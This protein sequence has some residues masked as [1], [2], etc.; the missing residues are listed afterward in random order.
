MP[1]DQEINEK[2]IIFDT[3]LRDGE[4][5]PGISLDPVEKVEIAIQL[6]RLGVN[7]I[8]AGFPAAS[9]G[10]F[11]GVSAVAQSF[12][13]NP[14]STICG[15]SRTAIKDIDKCWDAIEPAASR[16]IHTFIATSDIHMEKKLH[17]TRQQVI[18][19]AVNAVNYAK[20]F[21]DDVEFSPEDASRSDFKFMCD[22]LQAVVDSGATT[23]NIPDTVGFAYPDEFKQ[24]IE[25]IRKRVIGDYIISVHCHNDL[26]LAVAN[27]LAGV[28]AGARQVE[29][30]I[31]GIGER[32]GNA[33]L[34]EV[35]A[36]ILCK[37][38]I[39]ENISMDI[40][41]EHILETSMM[42]SEYTGYPVQYN[43]AI[44]GRNS[45]SHESG[46]HSHGVLQSPETYEIMNPEQFGQSSL[47]EIGKHTGKRAVLS[48][49]QVLGM[50][51]AN[52]HEIT[53]ECKLT[54]EE[55]KRTL[56]DVE[57]E[58]I[59]AQFSG[60]ELRDVIS[61]VEIVTA[62]KGGQASANIILTVNGKVMEI[63]D[64][65]HGEIGAAT[66]A[67][68]QIFPGYEIENFE[69]RE[70]PEQHGARAIGY[71]KIRVSTPYG[72]EISSYEQ[73]HNVTHAAIKAFIKAINCGERINRRQFD[74]D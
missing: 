31:N 70:I 46:I 26:G 61:D 68:Q 47:I 30:A 43:K 22:V 50:N 40:Q 71:S 34:E 35:V 49:L 51:T 15:L 67:I 13:D 20:T 19:E 42:V 14:N 63:E 18:N 69:S 21:T 25:D 37:N 52:I 27:S 9:M 4:Q 74:K 56:T 54:S 62:S 23:I 53:S 72:Q 17:M 7:V 57:I 6:G 64:N 36:A 12:K 45:F 3:T 44:V 39:F 59:S 8:E 16:R 5:S 28:T 1:L 55:N 48:R 58:K 32:A 73:D 24:R 29:V 10:D 65:N 66:S 41:T 11:E 33:A 60:E 2:L 38:K